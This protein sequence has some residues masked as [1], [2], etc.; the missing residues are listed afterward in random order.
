VVPKA[1]QTST[2]MAISGSSSVA[3]RKITQ[4]K[5]MPRDSMK[6]T[7]D[8]R[9]S[10]S[11]MRRPKILILASPFKKEYKYKPMIAKVVV[12]IPPPTE[13]G[14]QPININ[15]EKRINVVT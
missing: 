5:H 11:E 13:L 6:T 3:V 8:F 1:E 9:T 2:I 4:K 14:E 10:S 12:R 15:N 7:T